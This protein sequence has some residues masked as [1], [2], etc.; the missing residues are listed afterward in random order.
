MPKHMLCHAANDELRKP[1]PAVR[2]KHDQVGPSL[3]CRPQYLVRRHSG[4][5][6]ERRLKLAQARRGDE[7]VKRTSCV[8]SLGRQIVLLVL[9]RH[10]VPHHEVERWR[11]EDIEQRIARPLA[12]PQRRETPQRIA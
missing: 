4:V 7:R 6:A 10:H 1:A 8:A 9:L 5:V 3:V 2:G 12:K 11:I